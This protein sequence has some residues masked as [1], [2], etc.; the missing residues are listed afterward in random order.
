MI[1]KKQIEEI[2][3]LKDVLKVEVE[4]EQ[5]TILTSDIYMDNILLGRYKI[6]LKPYSG[7]ENN[8]YIIRLDAFIN[9]IFSHLSNAAIVYDR[10]QDIIPSPELEE[11]KQKVIEVQNE[12]LNVFNLMIDEREERKEKDK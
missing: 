10:L 9:V 8:P 2:M 12:A 4:K 1:N 7:E 5:T 11:Q 3:R 6:I